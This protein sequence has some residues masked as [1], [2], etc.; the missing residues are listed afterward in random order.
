MVLG[1]NAVGFRTRVEE[2]AHVHEQIY[3]VTY[4]QYMESL[5]LR[6]SDRLSVLIP[7]EVQFSIGD[8]PEGVMHLLEGIVLDLSGDGCRLGSKRPIKPNTEVN[9]AFTLP[10]D[11]FV[12]RLEGRVRRQNNRK[13]AFVQGVQFPRTARNLPAMLDLGRWVDQHLTFAGM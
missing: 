12:Y 5:D 6:K 3:F 4:P 9:L 7:A 10:G 1:S 2:V 13:Q 11:R 8:S